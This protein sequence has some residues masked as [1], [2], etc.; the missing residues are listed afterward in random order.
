MCPRMLAKVRLGAPDAP[1]FAGLM[2]RGQA[3]K[4]HRHGSDHHAMVM[5]TSKRMF[6]LC[7][8]SKCKTPRQ[9]GWVEI[10]EK[11]LGSEAVRFVLFVLVHLMHL[12]LNAP[13]W[14]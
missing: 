6:M 3:K 10:D 7:F 4:V 11:C 1:R 14:P 5:C 2:L 8:S 12:M 13:G 9:G